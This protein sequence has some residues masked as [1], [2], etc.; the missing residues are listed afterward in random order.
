MAKEY[1][2][3]YLEPITRPGHGE[4]LG[5]EDDPFVSGLVEWTRQQVQKL[6]SSAITEELES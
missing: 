3:R 1:E 6:G 5:M 2:G 4:P